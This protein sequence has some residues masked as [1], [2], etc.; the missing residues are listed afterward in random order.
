MFARMTVAQV[1]PE[2]FDEAVATVRDAF[3]PA[4]Q[5]QP[6]YQGFLV[7]TDRSRHQ[8]VGISMWETESDMQGS[9]GPS[10]YYAQRMADFNELTAAPSV[11]TTYEV[12]VREPCSDRSA[13]VAA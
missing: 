3:L 10:G 5:E 1:R 6:G 13:V 11:T 8:V 4:A 2:H 12:A 7:L 9:G